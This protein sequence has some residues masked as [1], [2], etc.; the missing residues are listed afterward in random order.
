MNLLTT[1]S[2]SLIEGFLPRGWDLAKIDACC[3]HPPDA[4][5]DRQPWWNADFQPV[6]CESI[7][8]FEVVFG[9]AIALTIQSARDARRP[10]ILILPVGPMGM[11][12]WAVRF[13]KE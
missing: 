1:I 6:V 2:G 13:L 10:A 5:F 4:I 3:S 9:H 12:R 7:E 8:D 11:Y